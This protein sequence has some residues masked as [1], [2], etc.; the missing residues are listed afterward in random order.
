MN[1]S[2][3]IYSRETVGLRTAGI[4]LFLGLTAVAPAAI[5]DKANLTRFGPE[6][7][8]LVQGKPTT[9]S[10]E[11]K[12]IDGPAKLVLQVAG[13]DRAW[14]KVNGRDVVEA[15]NLSDNGEVIIDLEL[16]RENTIEVTVPGIPEGELGV[17]VTQTAEGDLGLLRQGY[18]GLNTTDIERQRTLYDT[19]GFIGE[20]YPA[21]PETSTTFAQSLGFPDDYLIY[22]SLHSLEDP[23]A[24]PFVDTVEFRGN[25]YREEPPYAKLNHIGMTYGTYSTTD[26]DGDYAYFQSE[27]IEF[28]SAPATAPNGERFVF[29]K[30]QDG[31]YIKLIA[32]TEG[33]APTPGP[34]LVRLANTNMNVTDLERSRE[35]YRL[36]GFSESAPGSQAGSGDFAAAH[37]F[38]KPIEFE[39]LDISLGEDTDGA[40]LQLR[41]WKTPYD[42]EPPYP[43]PVNHLGIDRIN[44]YVEDLNAT[45]A[46]MNALG[47]EPLGPIGGNSGIGI[48]FF[49]D[50]DGI[51]VQLSGP[52]T[53]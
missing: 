11:F 6:T 9:Y 24:Q 29:M 49:L 33:E 47:F 53:E 51:K 30:D 14:V 3:R 17:R 44:F 15:Q 25:S 39:G 10:S 16:T 45:I 40:T 42:G 1:R 4:A 27:G 22:V 50:P 26:L 46:A 28:L 20:I 13:I 48:V 8:E 2:R 43:P 19:M 12:A 31:T 23:P 35:F 32:T 52:R 36:L 37:G 38:D 34:D 18:F 7:Y 21:G 41:Q 5:S